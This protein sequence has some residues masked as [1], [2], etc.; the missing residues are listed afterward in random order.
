MALNIC[1]AI[2]VWPA[3]PQKE[4]AAIPFPDASFR[5]PVSV[6]WCNGA[7]AVSDRSASAERHP[8][9]VSWLNGAAPERARFFAKTMR[10]PTD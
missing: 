7:R 2:I 10:I 4:G 8:R 3:I 6:T 9:R 5:S 1:G